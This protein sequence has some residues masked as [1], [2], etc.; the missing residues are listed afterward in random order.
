[1]RWDEARGVSIDPHSEGRRCAAVI[2]QLGQAIV[3]AAL[4]TGV[5]A[6]HPHFARYDNLGGDVAGLHRDLVVGTVE[7]PG[8]SLIDSGGIGTHVAGIVAGSLGA[9]YPTRSVAV[10]E[11]RQSVDGLT[12]MIRSQVEPGDISGLAHPSAR[13]SASA[14]WRMTAQ[15]RRAV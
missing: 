9:T 11:Q 2:P 10:F 14:F 15:V 5:D 13:S 4:G 12:E 1:L 3:W 8:K 6:S 7:G